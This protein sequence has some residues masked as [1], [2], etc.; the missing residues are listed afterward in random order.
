MENSKLENLEA[1]AFFVILSINGMILSTSQVL[2]NTCASSSLFN[3]LLI[4]LIALIIT[5]ILCLLSKPFLGKSLLDISEFLG[6]KTLKIVIGL[7]FVTYFTFRASLYLKKISDCLQI[8]YYPMTNIIFIAALFCIAAGIVATLKNYS[9][10]KSAVLIFPILLVTIIL[11]FV[12]NSKNFNFENI[13]P[14]LGN[15]IKTTFLT[16]ISNIFSFTGLI[17]LLFL[18]SKLKNP[19]KITKISIISVILS[20][21]FLLFSCASIMF[22]FDEQFSNTELLPL[23]VSVRSIEFGTF[24]QRLD[25]VFL[26]L[27]VLGF[28]CV[29]S[30]NTYIVIDILKDI[31]CV[32]DNKPF[33]FSYLLTIF[34]IVLCIKLN[35]TLE[36]LEGNISKVFFIILAIIVPFVLLLSANI[37]K[38]LEGGNI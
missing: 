17:Y 38:K 23:Y 27:C 3:V 18:P 8:V 26:F 36:F 30:L 29:L 28:I 13:Y 7:I 14:L 37:K 32:S 31:T 1:I 20:A 15:G 4:T 2:V 11:V 10:F 35:S 6:G 33:I 16:G 22:L 24:F 25:S 5:F 12:G 34:G 9:V 21:V 19:E